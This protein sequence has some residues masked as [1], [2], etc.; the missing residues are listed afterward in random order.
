MMHKSEEYVEKK[1][2]QPNPIWI[3]KPLCG[4][5]KNSTFMKRTDQGSAGISSS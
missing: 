2:I 1:A 3:M 5:E 4:E